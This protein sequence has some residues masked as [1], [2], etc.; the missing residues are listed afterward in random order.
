MSREPSA[1]PS[2]H[3]RLAAR[4]AKMPEA[5]RVAALLERDYQFDLKDIAG[6]L[7]RLHTQHQS[8]Q[9]RIKEL[10]TALRNIVFAVP[11]QDGGGGFILDH[12]D[13]EGKYIGTEIIDPMMVIQEMAS[14]AQEAFAKAGERND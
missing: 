5:L 8:D 2:N 13:F 7:R 12:H 9:L 14:I 3:E 4:E 10:E 6:L 11:A 1:Y